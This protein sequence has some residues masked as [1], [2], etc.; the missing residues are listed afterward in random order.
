[1]Q[2][3]SS[4]HCSNFN[5][6]IELGVNMKIFHFP[7]KSLLEIL[8]IP[9]NN[10]NFGE[11]AKFFVDMLEKSSI[12]YGE[13]KFGL[14][15]YILY[16]DDLYTCFWTIYS[17]SVVFLFVC[18]KIVPLILLLWFLNVFEYPVEW[19]MVIWRFYSFM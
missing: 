11:K 17:T 9:Y 8:V 10:T 5:Q 15:L 7:N 19:V 13:E 4:L 3:I 18:F 1:M 2:V 12:L 6:S 14:V 16:K